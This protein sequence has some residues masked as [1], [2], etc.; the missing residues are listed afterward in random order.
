MAVATTA[1]MNSIGMGG[2]LLGDDF[3]LNLSSNVDQ[4]DLY[5]DNKPNRFTV[6]LPVP[7]H[8]YN[9]HYKVALWNITVPTFWNV[10]TA[11]NREVYQRKLLGTSRVLKYPSRFETVV[12]R[13]KAPPKNPD[14]T[15]VATNVVD[16]D[17][18]AAP[19][20]AAA[21]DV[22]DD[23][24]E[25][26]EEGDTQ[27]DE[28]SAA[29]R[30]RRG[31]SDADR[32]LIRNI[33]L[34]YKAG[35]YPMELH[36]YARWISYQMGENRHFRMSVTLAEGTELPAGRKY[37][38]RFHVTPGGG[39]GIK[40]RP[41]TFWNQF[42]L[43][44]ALLDTEF[45][46]SFNG[47]AERYV[48]HRKRD[49]PVTVAVTIEHLSPST[50]TVE[51]PNYSLLKTYK[52]PI[53]F[54][55]SPEAFLEVLYSTFADIRPEGGDKEIFNINSMRRLEIKL[56]DKMELKFSRELGTFLGIDTDN[57]ITGRVE[58]KKVFTCHPVSTFYVY[59]NLVT[60]EITSDTF[61]PKLFEFV[62]HHHASGVSYLSDCT[63]HPAD[64]PMYKSIAPQSIQDVSIYITD[65][66][67][68]DIDFIEG[69]GETSV[70]LHLRREK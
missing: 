24:A 14:R 29:G 6:K 43:S 23:D 25:E 51:V 48:L 68:R 19:A 11:Q 49:P 47:E 21:D 9:H 52:L 70:I 13:I 45:K 22:A 38:I 64:I 31:T 28:P 32:A 59:S 41:K 50:E 16:P 7:L 37:R 36:S 17:A 56:P 63:P 39:A 18:A 55:E 34:K 62:P 58:S 69:G 10:I 65:Q 60:P 54:Y 12:V 35:G 66:E 4:Y 57:F 15:H 3:W 26:G 1:G 67:G 27:D 44:D 61:S 40:L 5:P 30:R 20:P 33:N 53:G 2:S 8:F 42:G 46:E